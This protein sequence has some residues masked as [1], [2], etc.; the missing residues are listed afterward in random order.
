[1]F[2]YL[3]YFACFCYAFQDG[4]KVKCEKKYLACWYYSFTF[5]NMV[6]LSALAEVICD[7]EIGAL[8]K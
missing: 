8:P 7:S 4:E 3:L 1:M 2:A 5:Q 6:Q